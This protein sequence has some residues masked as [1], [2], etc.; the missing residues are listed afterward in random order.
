MALKSYVLLLTLFT[1]S[2]L[3][4]P[5]QVYTD[6]WQPIG[7]LNDPYV[8]GVAIFAV[9]TYNSGLRDETQHLEYLKTVKGE[10]MVSRMDAGINYRLNIV[11]RKHGDG[12]LGNYQAFVFD[13]V[14][15]RTKK[16]I[17]LVPLKK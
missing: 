3:I 4:L 16:L 12:V 2:F 10:R 1:L 6:Q 11:A 17:Y 14:W 5:G 8:Q 9:E 13:D 7:N 15:F